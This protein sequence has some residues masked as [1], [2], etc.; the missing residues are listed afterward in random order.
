MLDLEKNLKKKSCYTAV[1]YIA[2]HSIEDW[3]LKS[4]E[5]FTKKDTRDLD[6]PYFMVMVRRWDAIL[7]TTKKVQLAKFD[8]TV[9]K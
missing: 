3:K 9:K 4:L 6:Q 5:E 8:F 2:W 1:L 7:A